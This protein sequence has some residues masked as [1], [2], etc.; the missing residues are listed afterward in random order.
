MKHVRSTVII[1]L[2]LA[3]LI[4]L[5]VCLGV[6]LSVKNINVNFYEASGRYRAAFER[7]ENNLSK[8]KGGSILFVD[9]EQIE[10]CISDTSRLKLVSF[11]KVLPCSIDVEICERGETLYSYY[12]GEYTVYD[13]DGDIM[14]VSDNVKST[15]GGAVLAETPDG[16]PNIIIEHGI[17]QAEIKFLADACKIFEKEFATLRRLV[18]S[19]SR[20]KT[21]QYDNVVFMLRSGLKIEI[22]DISRDV[23]GKI[24]AA[25]SKFTQ[26]SDLEKTK[27]KI[28][29]YSSEGQSNAIR[30]VYTV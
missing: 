9:G 11:K 19:V 28:R 15:S 8:L 5:T 18:E 16:S 13:G 24:K 4:A 20:E 21:P 10:D 30:A 22:A 1:S 3:F 26:L 6:V 7:T 14:Y 29:C 17:S 2:I 12:N 23:E 27:G 25:Y